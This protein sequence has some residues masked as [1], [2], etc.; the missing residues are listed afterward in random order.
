MERLSE[1]LEP[2][3]GCGIEDESETDVRIRQLL[4]DFIAIIRDVHSIQN[5]GRDSA[6]PE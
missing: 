5:R 1:I 4:N 3:S 6:Q 2:W